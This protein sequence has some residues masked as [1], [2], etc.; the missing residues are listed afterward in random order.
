[1][2][3]QN[4]SQDDFLKELQDVFLAET[5]EHLEAIEPLILNLE[6]NTSDIDAIEKMFRLIHT[7]KGSARSVGFEE[8][9][10]FVHIVENLLVKVKRNELEINQAIIDLLLSCNDKFKQF[11]SCL[12]EDKSG[13]VDT[14]DLTNRINDYM[15]NKD[16]KSDK[17][18]PSSIN[19]D[20]SEAEIDNNTSNEPDIE[21]N[22]NSL[23]SSNINS[24]DGF[25]FFDNDEDT[26]STKD[27]IST[28]SNKEE[29]NENK[30]ISAGKSIEQNEKLPD[31]VIPKN[32]SQNIAAADRSKADGNQKPKQDES[33]RLPLSRIDDLLNGFGELVILQA[34]LEKLHENYNKNVDQISKTLL[35]LGKNAYDLQQTAMSL[36]M[37]NLKMFFN[38]MQRCARDASKSLEKPIEFK[39]SGEDTQLDKT[40]V[41]G[42]VG[43]IPHIIRNSI[44][45]GLEDKETRVKL[46][47]PEHGTIE[48]KAYHEGSYFFLEISDDGKGVDKK[49]VKEKA[50]KAGLIKE[51]QELT[52]QEIDN[53]LFMSGF[54]TKDEASEFSGRGVGMDAVKS[55]VEEM[56]GKISLSST[57]GEGTTC[58]IQLSLNMA[59]FNGMV[60]KIEDNRY[61]LPSSEISTI[62]RFA[63]DSTRELDTNKRLLD[64]GDKTIPL[65]RLGNILGV[66]RSQNNRKEREVALIVKNNGKELALEVDEIIG[67]HRIVQKKIG[68]EIEGRKEIA[69]GSILGDGQV[70]L[71]LNLNGILEKAS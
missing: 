23:N 62:H 2:N 67:Q 27:E 18:S 57:E 16:G 30:E 33:I 7:I 59:I 31:K 39:S 70:A 22:A 35:Q 36:R 26:K 45:H 64:L 48:A 44:D 51:N 25:G 34:T 50:L 55:A 10:Q 38:Q 69:G 20:S 52:G 60:L 9:G 17:K 24:Q 46:G 37:I 68:K 12:I 14:E 11:R 40:I 21:S 65:Y 13:Q 28:T 53:L 29:I 61:I 15:D 66:S 41:D 71:I 1:M 49:R 47:K 54:S 19:V 3:F 32:V 56:R 42:L 6:I 63:K 5:E 58:T 8:F 4:L 43:V